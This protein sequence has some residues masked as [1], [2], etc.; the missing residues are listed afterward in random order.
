M[1]KLLVVFLILAMVGGAT[2]LLL[3]KTENNT[4]E[5]SYTYEVTKEAT[6][7]AE[8]TLTATCA[9]GDSFTAPVSK[10]SHVYAKNVT[11]PTCIDKGYTTFTCACGDTY[12]DKEVAA[13]GHDHSVVLEDTA[14]AATC[15]NAG[16]EADKKCSRCD[17]VETGAE[18]AALGHDE[19]RHEAQAPTCTEIGWDAYVTCSRCDYTTYA[20]IVALG[21][22]A[23]TDAAVAATCTENGLTE[24]SHCETCGET[25]VK[26]EIVPALGHS[27]TTAVTA[28]TCT[29]QG[30][31]IYTCVCGDSYVA[32]Y[33]D[34]LDHTWGEWVTTVEPTEETEGTAERVC[35]VCSEKETKT[36][37]ALEHTHKYTETITAPTCTEQGYTTYTCACG[38]SY[39]ADY[40]DALGHTWGEWM[41]TVEPT[42]ETEGTA[43][44]VCSVCSEKETKTLPNLE[45]THKYTETVTSPACT[46]QGYTIYTCT[47]GDSYVA[48]Y[49]DALGHTWGQWVTTLEPTESSEGTAERVCSVC[50]EKETKTLPALEHTHKYTE[51]VTAPT[52]TESGYTTYTCICGDSYTDSEVPAYGS[53]DYSV[54]ID[55]VASCTQEGI[56]TYICSR[57]DDQY[58]VT[59]TK[60]SHSYK[61]ELTTATCT[62]REYVTH[63]CACGDSFVV[64]YGDALG[65]NMGSWYT[66]NESTERRDCQRDGCDHFETRTPE[67]THSYT[68][69]VT[70]PTC[71]DQGYTTY[72]C[73]CGNS[74]QAD[75]AD[76]LGHDMGEW[77]DLPGEIARRDCNRTGCDYYETKS[78]AHVHTYKAVITVAPT[79]TKP[80][81]TT[82]TCAC[83]DTYAGDHVLALGHKYAEISR[84]DATCTENGSKQLRCEVCAAG[85]TEVL[86]STGHVIDQEGMSGPS[87][88]GSAVQY[89]Q[90]QAC[91]EQIELPQLSVGH[92]MGQLVFDTV[93]YCG[94]QQI[95]YINCADCGERLYTFGH[96]YAVETTPATCTAPGK[97][98]HTCKNCGDTYF[99]EIP[100]IGHIY[101]QWRMTKESTCALAGQ[102]VLDCAICDGIIETRALELKSHTYESVVSDNRIT[103]TC[104][105]C[106]HSYEETVLRKTHLVTFVTNGGNTYPAIYVADGAPVTVPNPEKEGYEFL[107]WYV[108]EALKNRYTGTAINQDVTLYA[109]WKSET[110]SGSEA[111]K[112]IFS[113][114]GTDFTF[115]VKSTV[116]LNN[117]NVK[118][119]IQ[120]TDTADN[121]MDIYIQA[122]TDGSYTIGC[123]DY[124]AATTYLVTVAKEITILDVGGSE[125][126]FATKGENGYNI[127]YKENVK[128]LDESYIYGIQ[129]Q[130]SVPYMLLTQDLLNVGDV[131]VVYGD[132]RYD[133]IMLLE[134][135]AE[136]TLGNLAVYQIEAADAEDV[137]VEYN[138]Y[139]NGEL[140][141]ENIQYAD[142]LIEDVTEMVEASPVYRQFSRAA[143]A[144]AGTVGKYYYKYDGIDV[145]PKFKAKDSTITFDLNIVATF[146]RMDPNGKKTDTKFT[147]T[148]NFN[149]VMKYK[150]TASAEGLDDFSF[151][152][153]VDNTAKVRLYASLATEI[154]DKTEAELAIFMGLLK[155][156]KDLGSFG[157]LDSTSAEAG[158]DIFIGNVPFSI[159]GI[160]V[161]IKLT[162]V[163]SFEAV[164]ELGVEV[165]VD[166]TIKV[167]IAN[168]PTNGF[169]TIWDFETEASLS[170]YM[171]GKMEISNMVKLEVAASFLGALE[172]Y[173]SVEGGPYLKVGG[174]FTVTSNTK[175]DHAI[176][177]GGYMEVGLKLEVGAGA[178]A[179]IP[180]YKWV[181]RK[182]FVKTTKAIYKKDWTL[183][184]KEIPFFTLGDKELPL[185]FATKDEEY[186]IE[187]GCTELKN[188]TNIIDQ[189]VIHQ[190]L[191][192][193]NK[194]GKNV[195]CEYY[196]AEPCL[197]VALKE[198]GT[199][200]ILNVYASK[201]TVRLKIVHKDVYKYVTIVITRKHD[202][203]SEDYLAPTCTDQGYTTY[204]CACGDTYKGDYE[205]ALG[206]HWGEWVTILTATE[207]TA[208]E[209][210]RKCS[211]CAE[212]ETRV[213]PAT[214]HIHNY[215]IVV[216]LPTCTTQ[217]YTTYTCVCEYSYFDH[218]ES[219]LGHSYDSNDKCVRCGLDSGATESLQYTLSEDGTYYSV[220]G[221]GTCIDADIRISSTY[222]NKPVTHIS[223]TAF[224]D[225]IDL[226]SIII[227]DSVISI[228]HGAFEGCDKLQ[229][230]TLP[231]VGAT[232]EGS[233]NKHFGYIFGASSSSGNNEYVPLFLRTVVITAAKC[234]GEYAFEGCTGLMSVTFADYSRVGSV[235]AYAFSGCTGLASVII[236]D[237]VTSIGDNI[238]AG[239]T[240]LT[241][242][243]L[244]DS[245]TSMGTWSFSNCMNLTSIRLPSCLTD[246]GDEAF[247][248]CSSLKSI[249]IPNDVIRIGSYAFS[250]C[251]AL[252]NVTIPDGV[253]TIGSYAF[254]GCTGL[255][256]ITVPNSVTSIGSGAFSGCSSLV[257]MT[258][259]FVG[260]SIKTA[261]DYMQ[262]PFGYIFGTTSYTGGVETKQLY[263]DGPSYERSEIYY[264][265][266]L[267]KEVTITGGNILNGAFY[268]CSGLERIVI[269]AG[270]T[271]IGYKA[272]ALC[273]SL[274]SIVIPDG[275]TSIARVAFMDCYALTNVTIPESVATIGDNAFDGCNNLTYNTYNNA[276]YLGNAVNPYVVLMKAK[277]T[278]ITSCSIYTGTK[279]IYGEAFSGCTSLRSITIPYGV[280][281]IGEYA[282]RKCSKLTSI[283]IPDSVVRIDQR[284]FDG[285]GRL[286]S[287]T[288]PFLGNE[289]DVSDNSY[290]RFFGHVFGIQ[291][292]SGG[293]P[294]RF[295]EQGFDVYIPSTLKTVTITGGNI[296]NSAFYN[297][298]GLTNI[299][300][301]NAVNYIG[302]GAF[303]NCS[304]LTSITIPSSVTS[305]G[306]DAFYGC[307]NLKSVYITD[308]AAWCNISFGN[309]KANPLW[310]AGN[311]YINGILATA[312]TIPANVKRIG[313]YAFYGYAQL[314]SVSCAN[315]NCLTGI[316]ESAF[317]GC[318]GLTSITIPD[319]VTSIGE[320]AFYECTGLKTVAIP[321]GV[322]RI[323]N[324]VFYKCE[325]LINV[326]IPD[327]VT[328]IDE[329]A[330]YSCENLTGITIPDSVTNIGDVAF[331]FCSSLTSI[332][333]PNSMSSIG[334]YAFSSCSN[335]TNIT[336]EGTVAQWEA[337]EKG[338]NWNQNTGNYT[339]YCTDGEI[340]KSGQVVYY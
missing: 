71:T 309:G 265:P 85:Y 288:L 122:V 153:D 123:N 110:I 222:N 87:C 1:K 252:R 240:G 282:F 296:P 227:P 214:G 196:L 79:C 164:G 98:V 22:N 37:P 297:C 170:C 333:I 199:I 257:S 298:T 189:K 99:E 88:T 29:K 259:P 73:T 67:H 169:T 326:V 41:T 133:V 141:V 31:T 260:G 221:I 95:G 258:L 287:I 224:K 173:L 51:T 24:G 205:D 335:L 86:G 316:G 281:N 243:I 38:D 201:I 94:S 120:V 197:D 148:L 108:D 294:T 308:L 171:M 269:P 50:S 157:E 262:Y 246:I 273:S 200:K 284:V 336:F 75:Y 215:T 204:F 184:S 57:C 90:C 267:L 103:Y 42:E 92:T 307:N 216:T 217:G 321:F 69:V 106:S 100:A 340:T 146:T 244:P 20:E 185:Y 107:G 36:L 278:S 35:S 176:V 53:H 300:L 155:D 72:T 159:Y 166:T 12:K 299:T 247:L 317:Y 162:D 225:C 144:F 277:S 134:I 334:N 327:G 318:S 119:Y 21:H 218:V 181:R 245:V 338:T 254:I 115:R 276:Y 65:H 207:H 91:H 14:K 268:E 210:E 203:V 61:R 145:K 60:L 43:E 58:T 337:I 302:N 313:N 332:T 270:V 236:P 74:Y 33:T 45:H 330:F 286:E 130:E 150:V 112:R 63:T 195:T 311:L 104:T 329:Y 191:E 194:E 279:V 232:K 151:I 187:V 213:I 66:L 82:Y 19:V 250:G 186:E 234:I 211:R 251:T 306:K 54:R 30:Y 113:D 188:L 93:E 178:R 78:T 182:G 131:V 109:A 121:R 272:F 255:M 167:G 102:E 15:L 149:N 230:I 289:I 4:H 18:L 291:D 271:R 135:M 280:T 154:E 241:S 81:Y 175:G 198:N 320:S 283:I 172:G 105:A 16:K 147:I 96:N 206:H 275:V 32:D 229:S 249:T 160:Y 39:V 8:G 76:T 83:G 11:E 266:S 193:M 46:A 129:E 248:N 239:C 238:F 3:P 223:D 124:R 80:G 331:A 97:T 261:E 132:D 55:Q 226:V 47:C 304:G 48:D 314:K 118:N 174:M 152:L 28:P 219:A 253:I 2:I 9:C 274:E 305:I 325:S 138:V 5:H 114:V 231:F 27:H 192:E 235:G 136:G 64:Y 177:G 158:D 179:E 315:N 322:T 319:G 293:I 10:T 220:T 116:R 44:R 168:T 52:C 17:S 339:V 161:D 137:F 180:W 256:D 324:R 84:V 310:N 165:R 140:N 56:K 295:P 68:A 26:Q 156:A 233:D 40:T 126:W 34:A 142:N 163:V 312:I 228:G 23:V 128:L 212:M 127:Q 6:C 101:G 290:Y 301:P 202:S 139:Y 208:G 292:F 264:I 125:F 111:T 190:S 59:E 209:E 237:G 183:Y 25:L 328:S 263:Y 70:A 77:C 303:Y 285:C 117:E 13:L 323:E 62:E 7:L 49:T 143:T 242:V 89:A